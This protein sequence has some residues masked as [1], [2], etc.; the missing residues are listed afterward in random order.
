MEQWGDNKGNLIKMHQHSRN[1]L[2]LEFPEYCGK[3]IRHAYLDALK[4]AAT[5]I[6]YNI[7]LLAFFLFIYESSF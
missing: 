6:N 5:Y 2:L 3:F 7:S 1:K 4:S